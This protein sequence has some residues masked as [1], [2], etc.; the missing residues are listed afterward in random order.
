MFYWRTLNFKALLHKAVLHLSRSFI[1]IVK[2][3]RINYLLMNSCYC[4]KYNLALWSFMLK[5]DYVLMKLIH[6][7]IKSSYLL[8]DNRVYNFI[9]WV[10]LSLFTLVIINIIQRQYNHVMWYITHYRAFHRDYYPR[11]LTS[12]LIQWTI[13]GLWVCSLVIFIFWGGKIR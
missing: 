7:Y 3:S 2:E 10:R 5:F 8:T 11:N 6:Y 4:Y 12:N 13:H 1:F 9:H